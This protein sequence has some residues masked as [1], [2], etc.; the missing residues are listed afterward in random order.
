MRKA[1]RALRTCPPQELPYFLTP[2]EAAVR[3]R[4][5]YEVFLRWIRQGKVPARK[6][7]GRYRIQRDFFA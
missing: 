3:A 2:E 5:E 6:F 7:G 1:L 4:V